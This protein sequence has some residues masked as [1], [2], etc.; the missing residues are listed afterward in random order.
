MT[1]ADRIAAL[2]ETATAAPWEKRVAGIEGDV[3]IAATG[4]WYRPS[5]SDKADEDAALIVALRNALPVILEALRAY[6]GRTP[7]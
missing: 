5:L 1:L 2:A 6:E 4:P 7:E 3:W